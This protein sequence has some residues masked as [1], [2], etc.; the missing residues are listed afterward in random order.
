MDYKTLTFYRQET[1]AV[2]IENG[3]RGCAAVAYRIILAEGRI[4]ENSGQISH[5][6]NKL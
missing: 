2:G 1:S 4:R 3:P 6:S 5:Q